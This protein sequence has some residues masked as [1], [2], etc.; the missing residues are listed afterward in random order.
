MYVYTIFFLFLY[1]IFSFR[2]NFHQCHVLFLEIAAISS[3]FYNF[4]SNHVNSLVSINSAVNSDN[5]VTKVE[6]LNLTL[7][8]RTLIL[9]YIYSTKKYRRYR[10]SLIMHHSGLSDALFNQTKDK[11]RPQISTRPTWAE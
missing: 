3:H 6:H 4:L 8:S 9:K 5:K 2:V 7:D 10:K 11:R 1:I